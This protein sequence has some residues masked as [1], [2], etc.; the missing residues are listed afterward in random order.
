VVNAY[1]RIPHY[2][3]YPAKV[4]RKLKSAV[5]ISNAKLIV[6]DMVS[7]VADDAQRNRGMG[8]EIEMARI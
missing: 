2:N 8:L 5:D 3:R 6:R 7:L 1:H 4:A